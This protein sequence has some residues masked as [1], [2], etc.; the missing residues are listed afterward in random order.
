M[1]GKPKLAMVAAGSARGE[2]GGAERFFTGLTQALC[3]AGF[4]AELVAVPSD[5]SS[6]EAIQRSYLRFYDLDLSRFDGV[7]SSKAPSYALRHPNHVCYLQHTMR[8]FYDMFDLEFP[9]P[10]EEL[11]AQRH[12]IQLLD[13]ALLRT[14][15]TRKL[16]A[17]GQEVSDRLKLYNGLEAQEIVHHPT[18]LGGLHEGK[19]DYFFLPGRLHRWKRVGL[20]IAAMRQSEI[21]ARLLIS[22]DG[23]DA[24]RFH[25]EA[26]GDPRIVFLGRVS[27]QQLAD[28]YANAR[29]AL[30]VP[31]R[32]DMGL[33]TFEAFHSG[34]PVITVHDSG[35][36][37][38][39]VRD[40]QTGLVC[41][42]E[43]SA[44]ARAMETLWADPARA[45]AMGAAGRDSIAHISWQ[46]VA[47]RLGTA[48]GYAD[49]LAARTK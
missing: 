19:A 34:T 42:P 45:A 24:A 31:M 4:D 35:E 25:A 30:F 29:A 36:P 20:A 49:F 46:N 11:R 41:A 27:D 16:L 13:T 32:E 14:P 17:I 1:S 44:L 15:R 37:A 47:H 23:E 40:G 18:T 43:P 5:E 2:L 38:N 7:I 6:F 39:I 8:V 21:P 22:G 9:T 48:L 12:V 10:S 26:E 33:I 28:L 3:N